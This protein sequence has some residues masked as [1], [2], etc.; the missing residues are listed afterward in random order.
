MKTEFLW[1]ALDCPAGWA[2]ANLQNTLDPDTPYI[3]LGRF[4]ADVKEGLRP[5]QNCVTIGWP[6]GK[7]GRKLFSGSA[8]FL[9]SGELLAAGKATWIAIQPR[10]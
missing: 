6:I 9:D 7:E 10:T 2:V 5:G 8:I 3:L 4:I 1:A